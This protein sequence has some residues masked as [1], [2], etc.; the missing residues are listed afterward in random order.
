M[1]ELTDTLMDGPAP[2]EYVP[3]PAKMTI[4]R[5]LLSA[6]PGFCSY[7]GRSYVRCSDG[8]SQITPFSPLPNSGRCCPDSHEGYID[9]WCL[10]GT[11][12]YKYDNVAARKE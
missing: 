4:V 12:R 8:G 6:L 3:P 2:M 11:I 1:S 10:Y 9:Q 7:C 5:R